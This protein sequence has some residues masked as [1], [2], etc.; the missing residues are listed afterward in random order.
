M[1][2]AEP[3]CRVQYRDGSPAFHCSLKISFSLKNLHLHKYHS[4]GKTTRCHW[5]QQKALPKQ[6]LIMITCS[7]TYISPVKAGQ[8]MYALFTYACQ[9]LSHAMSATCV[10]TSWAR[11]GICIYL[12]CTSSWN[13]WSPWFLGITSMCE[14]HSC[15]HW[16]LWLL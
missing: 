9:C 3:Y 16:C 6:F 7:V 5:S 10:D 8:A 15:M 11:L 13:R 12:Y 14:A 2:A 1:A 4:E